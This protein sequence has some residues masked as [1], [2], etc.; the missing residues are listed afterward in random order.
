MSEFV[1]NPIKP[2]LAAG[3]IM[4]GL[5]SAAN[6]VKKEKLELQANPKSYLLNLKSELRADDIFSKL[7]DNVIGIRKW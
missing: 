7:N 2:F 4:F 6:A 5:V 1:P 3:G